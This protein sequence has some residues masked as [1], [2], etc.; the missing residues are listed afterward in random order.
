M[1]WVFACLLAFAVSADS[2]KLRTLT[3]YL[4][5]GAGMEFVWIDSGRFVMG[6]PDAQAQ[7]LERL[8]WWQ[9]D[10]ANEKPAHAVDIAAGF[11]LARYELTQAQW[12]AVMRTRPWKGYAPD[13]PQAPAVCVSWHDAHAFIARLNAAQGDS[14]Y[15]LPSEA[16]WEYAARAGSRAPWY[17]GAAPDSLARH[18]WHYGN[19]GPDHHP[20]PVGRKSPNA[21]GLYDIYGNVWE[22]CQDWYLPYP[23]PGSNG[24]PAL[25]SGRVRVMRGGS[26][27]NARYLRSALRGAAEPN[28]HYNRFIGVRLVRRR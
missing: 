1:A 7:A 22:W 15:R 2:E 24:P 8:G 20:R 14:L 17:F 10:F 6:T 11:Y 9:E 3:A 5:G 28:L 21:W 25:L 13:E 23:V 18:A 12:T 16:E 19:S 4:P 26:V 27:H